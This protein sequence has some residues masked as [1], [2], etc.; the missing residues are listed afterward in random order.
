MKLKILVTIFVFLPVVLIA[1][2]PAAKAKGAPTALTDGSLYFMNPRWSPD[3]NKIALT[4]AKYQGLWVLYLATNRYLQVTDEIGAGFGYLWSSDSK[5]ILCRVSKYEGY[6]RLQAVKI[7]DIEKGTVQQLTDYRSRMTALPRWTD[8]DDKVYLAS[9]KGLE[10]FESKN[11]KFESS[12]S[13]AIGVWQKVFATEKNNLIFYQKG[14]TIRQRF[15]VPGECLNV[16]LSPDG[17]KIA[18]EIYGGNLYALNLENNK[19]VNLGLGYRPQWSPDSRKIVYMVSEDDGHQFTS[20]DIF[21]INIDG[22]GKTN[23]T[24]TRDLLEQNPSWS[25]DGKKLVYDEISSGKIF[26]IEIE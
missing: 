11:N 24:N 19:I 17:A 5:E 26:M 25:P 8:N 22:S 9:S 21:I 12:T 20:S 10:I 2:D 3:G 14:N 13:Q 15:S 16:E 7:F 23:V 4:E 1:E 6:R 18:F